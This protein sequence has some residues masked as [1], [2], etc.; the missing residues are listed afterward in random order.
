MPDYKL[1]GLDPRTFQQ[2]IQALAV[3]EIA[4]GVIV[5]GDG[6]DG[7]RDA[8]FQG[9]MH[10]P[11]LAK[12][13]DGHLIIQAKFRQ[14]PTG[15]TK[16]DAQ[17]LQ[18]QLQADLD[19]VALNSH[20]QKP[21]DYYILATNIDLTPKP[22]TGSD[23]QLRKTFE[24]YKKKLGLK[25]YDIWDGNKIRSLLDCH[26]NIAIAYGGHITTG[27][28]LAT[29]QSHLQQI[30]PDTEQ[31]LSEFLQGELITDQYARLRE[32]GSATERRAALAR[33]FVDL[34]VS[35]QSESEPPSEEE[36]KRH[37]NP[38]FVQQVIKIGNLRLD[39]KSVLDR[40]VS[41]KSVRNEA[42]PEDGRFVLIGGPGQ[43]KST[44]GQYLCQLYRA[45]IL[46]DRPRSK[47]SEEATTALDA[48]VDQC[49][50]DKVELPSARRFPVKVDLKNFADDL[51]KQKCNSL[52]EYIAGRI[53][54]RVS[55]T[56][57]KD[58]IRTWLTAYP[59][60]LVLDGLDE[61]PASGNRSAV[62]ECIDQLTA[63]CATQDSD[64]LIVAT[65]RPQGYGD[66]FQGTLYH[67]SYL[68]PLSTQRA[69]HYARR[70]VEIQH[71]TDPTLSKDILAR[72]ERAATRPT[73]ERLMRSPLQVTILAVL[74][75]LSG[76]L[77]D[78]RWEL[79]RR[80]YWT[81]FNRETQ[82]GIEL[83]TVLREHRKLIDRVHRAVGLRLQ[84]A[85]EQAG[86]NNAVLS[87]QDFNAIVSSQLETASEDEHERTSTARKIT[88]AALDR[89]VFL[90]SP[91]GDDIGF[92]IRSLQEF[93]AAEALMDGT[94]T[95]IHKRLETIAPFPYW[96]NVFL[97]AA[98][99]CATDRDYMVADIINLC[100]TLSDES[101]QAAAMT[102][103][104][105][106]LALDLLEDNTFH[107]K[108]KQRRIVAEI[109]LKLLELP[110]DEIHAQLASVYRPN[111]GLDATYSTAL[112][113]MLS[114]K[115]ADQHFGAWA[116]LIPLASAGHQWAID[117]ANEHWPTTKQSQIELINSIDIA[118]YDWIQPK[119]IELLPQ[120]KFH[121][122]YPSSHEGPPWFKAAVTLALGR[123][124]RQSIALHSRDS[125]TPGLQF[126]YIGLLHQE[127]ANW[128]QLGDMP[129][130]S[131]DWLP[132]L[133]NARIIANPSKETVAQ[134]L[135]NL[136][137]ANWTSE[138][139]ETW[140]WFVN[141]VLAACLSHART[142]EDLL[143]MASQFRSGELLDFNQWL[144]QEQEWL[145][146]GI[147]TC[148]LQS[149]ID[150]PFTL[151]TAWTTFSLSHSWLSHSPSTLVSLNN[152]I[153]D[154]VKTHTQ[155]STPIGR[156]LSAKLAL[157]GII[158][159][160]RTYEELPPERMEPALPP[161]VFKSLLLET[162]HVWLPA[163]ILNTILPTGK[164]PKEWM[165][166]LN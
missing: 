13:W 145:Q 109:A 116:T 132:M 45:A 19:K 162:G 82:R 114:M 7:A 28:V 117:L 105:S 101:N 67:H 48:I 80:Y 52:L 100:R 92:E 87:K 152:Y 154:A 128:A 96:R 56:L 33:V 57:T 84:V 89:L 143:H 47:L 26:R 6:P 135:E 159:I 51:A 139:N 163:N 140:N 91:H 11:S 150:S 42:P 31:A 71:R 120:A 78:D 108:P 43:G 40:R 142:T 16:K 25:D 17:W 1:H 124:E 112:R 97:F 123:A 121:E 3:K 72:L 153:Q 35:N 115:N 94:D 146:K 137:N 44:L 2:L 151:R 64:M 79:F 122:I 90:V 148:D 32:A 65:S 103:A 37:A 22:K 161:S 118:P 69:L 93:M 75:E 21:P 166:I 158:K 144:K 156:N 62:L 58:N 74:A 165:D 73:T 130:P 155:A 12:P 160:N 111:W 10:Y 88:D 29:M 27:G 110:G 106:R 61:V 9:S 66:A 49:T 149:A 141:W 63:Q 134:E 107:D 99:K 98:G 104:G 39:R 125:A 77:P 126:E 119:L 113:R 24:S 157:D 8:A 95:Q 127:Q 34:P 102:L 138:T 68:R 136:A 46:K 53:N 54:S 133:A 60:L 38:S 5:Y 55:R 85:S 81:I 50:Q 129:N 131:L 147:S 41:D 76:E 164:I 4:P 23:A 59:W 14:K 30:H 36:E 86:Q 70:L 20:Q 18:A 15:D 83:S